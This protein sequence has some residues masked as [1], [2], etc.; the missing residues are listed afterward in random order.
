MTLQIN[1]ASVAG[2]VGG[3]T[4]SIYAA[5]KHAVIG[6]TKSVVREVGS[7]GIR[8]NCIAPGTI[9]TPMTQGMNV[10]IRY[11]NKIKTRRLEYVDRNIG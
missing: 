6:L 7:R 8:V 5:S 10:K 3:P 4:W 2:V 11:I 9:N 1:A